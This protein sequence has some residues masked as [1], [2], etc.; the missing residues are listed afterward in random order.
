MTPDLLTFAA[1][2]GVLAAILFVAHWESRS[3]HPDPKLLFLEDL[4][5]RVRGRHLH[6]PP[7][8]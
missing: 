1:L 6:S 4:L 5:A 8:R 7:R 2:I 3:N